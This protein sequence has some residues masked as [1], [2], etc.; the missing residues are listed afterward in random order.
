M[1]VGWTVAYNVLIGVT[2]PAD[3]SFPFYSWLLSLAGWLVVP[4]IVGGATGYLVNREIDK[5]RRMPEEDLLEQM[6]AQGS[7]PPSP[8]S[9]GSG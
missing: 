7:T 2:S 9:G 4:A 3:T 6:T 5:Q 8:R 1:L